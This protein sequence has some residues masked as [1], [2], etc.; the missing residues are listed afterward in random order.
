[1]TTTNPLRVSLYRNLLKS[2]KTIE[3]DLALRALLCLPPH[4]SPRYDRESSLWIH[5][6]PS[7]R[8][9]TALNVIV[10][11]LNKVNGSKTFY[12]P[13]C[14]HS[15]VALTP[16]VRETFRIGE[17]D[18]NAGF[19][20]LKMLQGI[21]QENS[22]VKVNHRLEQDDQWN[23]LDGNVHVHPDLPESTVSGATSSVRLLVAHPL[24][25]RAF[26]HAIV[27]VSTHNKQGSLGFVINQPLRTREGSLVTVG[28]LTSH[29]TGSVFTT[30][31]R[32]NVVF[33]G[34]PVG[35]AHSHSSLR[36][37]FLLYTGNE[38]FE[39]S[40]CI[41]EGLYGVNNVD[42]HFL[43]A[44]DEGRVKAEDVMVI[45]GY[46]G[47]GPHQLSGEVDMGTW[48]P[49]T[50]PNRDVAKKVVFSGQDLVNVKADAHRIPVL[51]WR[52]LLTAM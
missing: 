30:H 43:K 52:R 32:E 35:S 28:S 17:G 15:S 24:L 47:W 31:L 20:G 45:L 5:P 36:T 34:G 29:L 6:T 18:I 8:D 16:T 22:H 7:S 4:F 40:H 1:M 33:S 2:A 39:D 41:A 26:H 14:P 21:V 9:S 46:A 11:S 23:C 12:N 44:M 19:L 51:V 3:S 38:K 49:V 42:E 27:L 25:D 50:L 13:R 48:F 10:S 37:L